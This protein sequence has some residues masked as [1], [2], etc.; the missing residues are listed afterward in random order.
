MTS[1]YTAI[2]PSNSSLDR[3][4][5]NNASSF[6]IAYDDVEDLRGNWEVAISDVVYSNCINTF[7][8]ETVQISEPGERVKQ[9]E[10]G[11]RVYIPTQKETDPRKVLIFISK[12]I[13]KVSDGI[14]RILIQPEEKP[15]VIKIHIRVASGWIA[16]VSENLGWALG[17]YGNAFSNWDNQYYNRKR[18]WGEKTKIKYS[19]KELYVDFVPKTK[20]SLI[21]TVTLKEKDEVIDFKT[22]IERFNAAMN[23]D[24]KQIAILEQK[25]N[26]IVID[27]IVDEDI[28]LQNNPSFDISL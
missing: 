7:S 1:S 15:H 21:K 16:C 20:S 26:H 19:E 10:N 11:C 18:G 28:V 14:L 3:F 25:H 17:F 4:P 6:S 12:Y 13:E 2:L 23:V 8:N 22:L 5:N 27:K 24:G 9:W